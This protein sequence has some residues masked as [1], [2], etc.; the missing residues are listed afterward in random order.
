[1]NYALYCYA[2]TTGISLS[3][4]NF[5][6]F[7]LISLGFHVMPKGS[8]RI[9]Q[10]SRSRDFIPGWW[11]VIEP[12]LWVM[13][14][15]METSQNLNHQIHWKW[16]IWVGKHHVFDVST[17]PFGEETQERHV[18]WWVHG[19][20]MVQFGL[21]LVKINYNDMGCIVSNGL[22]YTADVIT[23]GV[24]IF[25]TMWM[26]LHIMHNTIFLNSSYSLSK[27]VASQDKA[28]VTVFP[29]LTLGM[30]AIVLHPIELNLLSLSACQ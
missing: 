23:H 20:L 30:D 26:W 2:N 9:L 16:L 14:E 28:I 11:T 22:H 5:F 29:L 13:M 12:Y 6:S 21:Q 15:M 3:G 27:T 19:W 24:Y 17:Q 10:E 1:M 18:S 8:I 25:Y 4:F 7:L